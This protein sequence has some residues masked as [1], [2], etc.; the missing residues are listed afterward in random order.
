MQLREGAREPLVQCLGIHPV[1]V[2]QYLFL[3]G[4]PGTDDTERSAAD[5]AKPVYLGS[6]EDGRSQV[7]L[8]GDGEGYTV[9]GQASILPI[10]PVHIWKEQ[11][12]AEEEC[13]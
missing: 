2:S 13:D 6:H 3:G 4:T 11:D 10:Y 5:E 7:V 8:G 9:E 12:S 1:P